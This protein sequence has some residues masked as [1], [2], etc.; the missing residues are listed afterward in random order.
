MEAELNFK[1]EKSGKDVSQTGYTTRYMIILI[2]MVSIP[3][4][5]IGAIFG[6]ILM[7]YSLSVISLF[8]VVALSGVV[9]NDSLVL[10]DFINRAVKS[11]MP[12]M[13][14]VLAAGIQR[15][16]PIILT[17]L[18]TFGG[19]TPMI[20]EKSRQAKMMIPMAISL[21]FGILFSPLIILVLVPA[22]YMMVVDIKTKLTG[23][24]RKEKNLP[25]VSARA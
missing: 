3:F 6:H 12:E 21:G 9:V 8:G 5:M 22:L 4:G 7:G 18:T 10:I 23:K 25:E 17:T 19:L 20:L 15:F 13:D 16:R 24:K 11:G 1:Q 2:I 14:A